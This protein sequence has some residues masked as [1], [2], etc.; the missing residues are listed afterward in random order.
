MRALQ[1]ELDDL[2]EVR[3]RDMDQAALRAQEDE[4]ELRILRDRCEILEDEKHNQHSEVCDF[5]PAL[6]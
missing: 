2:R 5:V 4:D 3:Q 6:T 1:K